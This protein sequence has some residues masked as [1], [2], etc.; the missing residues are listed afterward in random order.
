MASKQNLFLGFVNLFLGIILY[1]GF[2]LYVPGYLDSIGMECEDT[3]PLSCGGLA[4]IV[5]NVAIIVSLVGLAQILYWVFFEREKEREIS[6]SATG[7]GVVGSDFKV[8]PECNAV[9]DINAK[10]CK[11][12]GADLSRK[13][14]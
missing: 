4:E 9:N 12:C 14:R 5:K 1:A 10:F 11:E 8:C 7:R 6:I 2:V 3:G 13:R